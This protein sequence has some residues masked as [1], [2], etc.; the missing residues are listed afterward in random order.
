MS[1]WFCKLKYAQ[2]FS[3]SAPA[4]AQ[5]S[6]R[7]F[8]V[9]IASPTPVLRVRLRVAFSFISVRISR[10]PSV[11]SSSG[12]IATSFVGA[13]APLNTRFR[14]L[15]FRRRFATRT[16]ALARYRVDEALFP[17]SG[18]CPPT[19]PAANKRHAA[20]SMALARSKR[21]DG[22]CRDSPSIKTTVDRTAFSSSSSASSAAETEGFVLQGDSPPAVVSPETCRSAF[23]S[24]EGTSAM[25]HPHLALN[26]KGSPW[27]HL[28]LSLLSFQNLASSAPP[29]HHARQRTPRSRG[30]PAMS[31]TRGDDIASDSVSQLLAMANEETT[32]DG[33]CWDELGAG[34][35]LSSSAYHDD[36]RVAS[37]AL[38]AE[39]VA[40]LPP[41][42]GDDDTQVD[43][44]FADLMKL[45]VSIVDG[46]GAASVASARDAKN[47]AT[48]FAAEAMDEAAGL[49]SMIASIAAL[50]ESDPNTLAANIVK[51]TLQTSLRDIAA[52]RDT[53]ISANEQAAVM[54]ASALR[55]ALAT[56]NEHHDDDEDLDASEELAV[57][58]ASSFEDAVSGK[59]DTRFEETLKRAAN[60]RGASGS[61]RKDGGSFHG[62]D[63]ESIVFPDDSS[64]TSSLDDLIDKQLR[65]R[66]IPSKSNAVSRAG[67]KLD[68]AKTDQHTKHEADETAEM[69]AGN[70]ARLKH[71]RRRALQN[72]LIR[73][74]LVALPV[75]VFSLLDTWRGEQSRAASALRAARRRGVGNASPRK[76]KTEFTA[77]TST[78]AATAPLDAP[79]TMKV[80][81]HSYQ[82]ENGAVVT[83]AT[84]NEERVIRKAFGMG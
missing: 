20:S 64:D 66:Q 79:T 68:N 3:F 8:F 37:L 71:Q 16:R 83:V 1:R 54:W 26:G 41:Y 30:S 2:L 56:A 10:K 45:H 18:S 63:A 84:P 35:R 23:V 65:G 48:E 31:R 22:S 72:R 75:L 34:H 62:R 29:N 14:N 28:P 27:F 4:L 76:R 15:T 70:S 17:S 36:A 46:K 78:T 53:N 39:R 24:S 58:N 50:G 77:K 67:G 7:Y 51:L 73:D 33:R 6:H 32:A 11:A 69:D 5:S 47:E 13:K 81:A 38:V 74:A 21:G 49:V 59:G 44:V 80:G 55:H 43:A 61:G 60:T 42:A 19:V 82:V 57:A 52:R 40:S 12:V 25:C 9:S